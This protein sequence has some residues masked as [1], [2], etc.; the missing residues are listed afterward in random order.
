MKKYRNFLTIFLL[1][2]VS[3][4]INAQTAN[5]IEQFIHTAAINNE[6]AAWF[7]L[8]ASDDSGIYDNYS[9]NNAF[10]FAV[11]KRWLSRNARA[12]AN[13]S[14]RD[15]SFLIMQ[16]F[17]MKGGPMYTIF[18]TPHYAYREMLQRDIIQGRT[19][20]GMD[21][22]GDMLLYMVG[23]VLFDM[24]KSPWE[25]PAEPA[26]PEEII[27]VEE[28]EPVEVI[29]ETVVIEP[30][31]E[32]VNYEGTLA[33][34][35]KLLESRAEDGGT[36]IFEV[37]A[38]ESI[39]PHF[40]YYGGKTVSI[41]IR[42]DYARHIVSLNSA[43]TMFSI[44][45]GV[46]LILDNNITIAGRNDNTE[47]LI[48]ISGGNLKINNNAIITGNKASYGGGVH[49]LNGTFEM[50]GGI[51]S[52][53]NA[54]NGGG[55]FIGYGRTFEM[56][57]GT[58][59]GNSAFYGGGVYVSSN[60]TFNKT[61]G[62]TSGNNASQYG[63][64]VYVASDGVFKITGGVIS[65]NTALYSG[66]GVG[67]SNGTFTMSGGEISAN[68]AGNTGG[69]VFVYYYGVFNK[70]AGIIYGDN[71]DRFSNAVKDIHTGLFVKDQGHAVYASVYSETAGDT[72]IKRREDNADAQD[73]LSL[74]YTN[75]IPVW[76]GD[77]E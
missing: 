17:N 58:I 33:Y 28:P 43:G 41:T 5:V 35:L 55:V 4:I 27:I 34:R 1:F 45:T 21:V 73:N 48:I 9:Y 76:S 20:P 77:W 62:T 63:G 25:I 36:Y 61:G 46:T 14:L 42:G 75:N 8:A 39:T 19:A 15:V 10:R 66:G 59:S 52:G 16:A 18:K 11:E 74:T 32:I 49:F 50:N 2:A 6:Q 31:P 26:E 65:G 72:I 13:I 64:G 38:N 24:D 60:G 57:G 23:R 12:A 22:T 67:V 69:G 30:E 53:N 29:P 3:Y 68:T 40:L 7:V 70:T 47:S 37:S 54:L 51:I 71:N 44:G 56:N